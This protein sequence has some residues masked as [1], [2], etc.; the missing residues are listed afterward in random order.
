MSIPPSCQAKVLGVPTGKKKET[1]PMVL[2]HPAY[3]YFAVAASITG[4][5]SYH[6][7][8]SHKMVRMLEH[9]NRCD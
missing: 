7:A 9:Y 5:W 2:W 3:E 6:S 8:H 1:I 4:L